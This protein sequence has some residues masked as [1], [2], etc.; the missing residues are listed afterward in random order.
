[1]HPAVLFLL[2]K[3]PEFVLTLSSHAYAPNLR[4][5]AIA[6]GWNGISALLVNITAPT[7]G[8]LSVPTAGAAS[9]PGGLKIRIG[10]STMVSAVA[11][12][13]STSGDALTAA[14]PV[15]VENLGYIYAPGGQGGTG[16]S[17][18]VRNGS[19]GFK[20]A[21]GG[22]GGTGNGVDSAGS[23]TR[24][25]GSAGTTQTDGG[26][27][28]YT[29]KGGTGGYGGTWGENGATGASGTTNDPTG[30]ANAGIVGRSAGRAIVGDSFI[31][32]VGGTRGNTIGTIA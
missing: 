12:S 21:T 28:P 10:A 15:T 24:A 17:A 7:I 5:L 8:A 16:G 31:T 26:F 14:Q 25:A 30:V 23:Q 32:W 29:A 13:G 4:S 1:M 18:T 6:A 27:P 20:T 2:A 22:L 11:A 9:F 19:G 3:K